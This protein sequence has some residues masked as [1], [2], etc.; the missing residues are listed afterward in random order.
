MYYNECNGF[1]MEDIISEY[2]VDFFWVFDLD[3]VFYKVDFGIYF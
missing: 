1:D 2:C 3:N